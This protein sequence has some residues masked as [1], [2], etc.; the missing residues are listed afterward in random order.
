VI[1]NY[2]YEQGPPVGTYYSPPYD[3][4]YLYSWVPYSFYGGGS[5]FP[6]FFILNDFALFRDG[7]FHRHFFT[8][9]FFDTR[10]RAFGRINPSARFGFGSRGFFAGPRTFGSAG[11]GDGRA[12]M[13]RGLAG[14]R[15][16]FAGRGAFAGR[17]TP[18][19]FGR[20]F[21][22]RPGTGFSRS[23]SLGGFRG[24]GFGGFRGGGHR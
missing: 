18:G 16:G 15:F 5:F 1:N 13:N 20:G 4:S 8:N 10:T 2:Y 22:S 9:L 3:Y 21:A 17:G 11:F 7:P 6:G 14:S 19:G 12:L 24:G 23:G